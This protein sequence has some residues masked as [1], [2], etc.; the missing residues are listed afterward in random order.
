MLPFR[1]RDRDKELGQTLTEYVL[2]VVLVAIAGLVALKLF[3]GQIKQLFGKASAEIA[4]TT[5]S[6]PPWEETALPPEL[7]LNEALLLFLLAGSMASDISARRIYNAFT[8]P[9]IVCG[10]ALCFL[11]SWSFL[12]GAMLAFALSFLIYYPLCRAGGMGLGDLKLMAAIG[13]LMGLEF[14][15][16]AQIASALAGGAIAFAVAVRHGAAISTVRGA[17]GI[18]RIGIMALITRKRLKLPRSALGTAIPYGVAI[19]L[20][21]ASVW[22]LGWPG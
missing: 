10:F 5:G 14:W 17:L 11:D 6:P 3:G 15:V 20:G 8:Y 12:G 9:A 2:I 4:Q 16:K 21:T 19:G 18:I 13:A 7:R 1:R 22:W